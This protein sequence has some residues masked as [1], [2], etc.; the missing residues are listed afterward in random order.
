M[1]KILAI[2][3]KQDNLTAI[4]ALLTSLMPDCTAITTRSGAEGIEKAMAELPDT[5]LL[6]LKMPEMDGFEVC[7]RLKSDEAT[8]HIPIIMLTAVRTDSASRIEGLELGADAFLTKP[9]NEGELVAQVRVMLRIKRAEDMMRRE[10]DL[11]EDLV[12]QRTSSLV[13]ANKKMKQ[14]IEERRRAEAAVRASLKEREIL[15]RE[16]HHRVKNNMQIISSLLR[17][18]AGSVKDEKYAALLQDSQ[19]RIKSMA[20]IHERLYL[21]E[22]FA[23]VDFAGY[24]R[25]LARDL[26]RSYEIDPS[27]TAL[28][29]EVEDV[30][31]GINNAIPCGLIMNELISNSL[32]HAFA[33]EGKGELEIAFR[34]VSGDEVE[35]IVGDNGVG[36]PDDL[37]FRNTE[38]MGLHIVTMLAEDQLK[39]K[40]E[41]DRTAGT[42]F[43]VRFK[44]TEDRM[45]V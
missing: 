25:G 33:Q 6:D 35:L 38:S 17:L 29:I 18:Q 16:I 44:V 19:H 21:S 42:K 34:S 15:L 45:R 30:S 23:M 2:D 5:I 41:L 37:D 12:K 22:N 20:L 28:K 36:L 31:L 26:Y 43:H 1:T 39:G 27:K 11:L 9:I 40:I 32:K 4:S 3:D 7:K 24:V 14:E 13:D 10:K 8:C